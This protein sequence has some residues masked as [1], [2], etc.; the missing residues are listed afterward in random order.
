VTTAAVVALVVDLAL[1]ALT[2]SKLARG[3]RLATG[4]KAL[5]AFQVGAMLA[6]GL[7]AVAY[8]AL[9]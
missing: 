3:E 5:L 4:E 9:R 7:A 1:L 2:L 6:I 8:L